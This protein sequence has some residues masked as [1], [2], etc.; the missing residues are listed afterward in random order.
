MEV[1]YHT[2]SFGFCRICMISTLEIR[3][4][5]TRT[6]E[7][8]WWCKD[9]SAKGKLVKV[10]QSLPQAL[11]GR[12]ARRSSKATAPQT[13]VCAF[14]Q[15]VPLHRRDLSPRKPPAAVIWA[16][17][18]S[19]HIS[20]LARRPGKRQSSAVRITR[21]AGRMGCGASKPHDVVSEPVVSR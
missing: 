17:A 9:K 2:V 10:I 8:S 6:Q 4:P 7:Q 3:I 16:L 21:T 15:H 18:S 11:R 13:V 12:G 1:K 5:A 19:P 20:R 14:N